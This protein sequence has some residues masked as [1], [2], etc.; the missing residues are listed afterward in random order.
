MPKA[1]LT[2]FFRRKPFSF[3][4]FSKASV[5]SVFEKITHLR[6]F[7]LKIATSKQIPT[8]VGAT[9]IFLP[10]YETDLERICSEGETDLEYRQEK[11]VNVKNQKFLR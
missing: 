4:F 11:G 3:L 10:S 8:K 5:S 9:P 1:I 2:I 7:A 6:V